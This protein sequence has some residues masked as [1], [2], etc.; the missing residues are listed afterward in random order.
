[1]FLSIFLT[2]KLIKTSSNPA[3][4]LTIKIVFLYLLANLYLD[5]KKINIKYC[6]LIKLNL[7][8]I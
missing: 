8:H 6:K 3:L 1:M 5:I 7:Q 2:F 4:F